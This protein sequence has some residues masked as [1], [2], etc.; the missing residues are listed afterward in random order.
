MFFFRNINFFDYVTP[1]LHMK[2]IL[3]FI[4]YMDAEYTNTQI[5]LAFLNSKFL[6]SNPLD[7]WNK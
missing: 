2:W 3:L 6:K 1:Y 4:V 7:V 5:I